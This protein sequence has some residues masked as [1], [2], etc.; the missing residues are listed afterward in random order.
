MDIFKFKYDSDPTMPTEG[1]LI[2]GLTSKMWVERYSE[3]GEFEL[4]SPLSKGVREFLP[5]GT[6][7]S[8]VDTYEVMIVE[9]HEIEDDGESDPI[10]KTTGRSLVSFLEERYIGADWARFSPSVYSGGGVGADSLQVQIANLINSCINTG[11]AGSEGDDLPGIDAVYQADVGTSVTRDYKRGQ[12]WK[13]VK[14]L[15]P[16]DDLGI[17]SIRRNGFSI[18]GDDTIT[19]IQVYAGA[20]R[21][22]TVIFSWRAGDLDQAQYLFTIKNLK[23]AAYVTGKWIGVVVDGP[24]EGF[25][26]R[27]MEVDASDIDEQFSAEPAG[28]DL[29][30][31]IAKMTAR[32][33]EALRSQSTI[34]LA[35][36]DIP[37]IRQYRYRDDF[38]LGDIIRLSGNFGE[39]ANMRITEYT[40]IEDE[41]GESSHPTLTL[42]GV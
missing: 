18:I 39:I 19:Q 6:W 15:L 27:F 11:S 24:E 5:L 30:S 37:N 40:E 13:Q 9:N 14:D 35:Q 10:L 31:V 29:T 23:N 32:G 36:A 25:D 21:S 12:L 3:F 17:R 2:N 16:I 41:N 42:P 26:R 7:I 8:H 4:I 33:E 38:I 1:E 22:D 20:D 34:V 28:G